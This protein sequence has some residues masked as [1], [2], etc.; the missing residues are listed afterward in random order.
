MTDL[1]FI[2]QSLENRK[3]KLEKKIDGNWGMEYEWGQLD[4]VKD[5][6]QTIK[7]L[8]GELKNERKDF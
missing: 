4:V 1:E 3:R 7:I 8:K 2:E 5:V 6:I